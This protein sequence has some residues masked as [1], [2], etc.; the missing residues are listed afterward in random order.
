MNF[1]LELYIRESLSR[2]IN[3]SPFCSHSFAESMNSL[4]QN[5]QM[6]VVI[7]YCDESDNVTQTRY[8]DSKFLNRP[9]AEELLSSTCESLTNLREDR[10]RQLSKKCFLFHFRSSFCSRE[11]QI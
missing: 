5:C 1:G 9:N 10:L 3:Q 8:L 11:N 6:D 7:R 4:L 2:Y